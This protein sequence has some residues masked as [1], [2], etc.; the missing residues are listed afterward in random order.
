MAKFIVALFIPPSAFVIGIT[1]IELVEFTRSDLCP[2][3]FMTEPYTCGFSQWLDESLAMAV[4]AWIYSL[5]CW[6]PLMVTGYALSVIFS[7]AR[8]AFGTRGR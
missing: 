3:G 8:S 2:G 7:F 4:F 6:A 5:L 1:V